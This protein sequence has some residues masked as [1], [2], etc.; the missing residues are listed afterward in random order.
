MARSETTLSMAGRLTETIDR[1]LAEKTEELMTAK[2]KAFSLFVMYME[3]QRK[4]HRLLIDLTEA[5]RYQVKLYG[6][7]NKVGA[8]AKR[9]SDAVKRNCDALGSMF[10]NFQHHLRWEGL[11]LVAD[12]EMSLGEIN[13]H[14]LPF[15]TSCD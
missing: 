15:H 3:E 9:N 1:E 6:G 4:R 14:V 7:L 8:A 5:C 12:G 11:L 13:P 10:V 2:W